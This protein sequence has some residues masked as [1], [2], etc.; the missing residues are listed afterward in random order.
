MTE[1]EIDIPE[2]CQWCGTTKVKLERYPKDTRQDGKWLCQF[3]ACDFGHGKNEITK[4]IAAMLNQHLKAMN[5]DHV[6]NKSP[7]V[8]VLEMTPQEMAEQY[9]TEIEKYHPLK[10]FWNRA[11]ETANP[12]DENYPYEYFKNAAVSRL[13][14]IFLALEMLRNKK[15]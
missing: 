8:D 10:S 5:S 11:N 1:L 6:E 3:C 15:E 2:E 12:N 13:T 7:F 9:W 4:T 14:Q